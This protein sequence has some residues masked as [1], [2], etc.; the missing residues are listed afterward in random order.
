MKR[1][2]LGV[3]AAVLALSASAAVVHAQNPMNFGIAAG[4]TFPTGDLGEGANTG[5]HGMVTLGAM[6]AMVPF[7]VRIDGMY[8][9][10][11][12]DDAGGF[13]GASSQ[14]L[15]ATANAVFSIPGMMV[16]SPYI[17]GGVGYYSQ[18]IKTDQAD[19]DSDGNIGLNIGIGAKFNLSGF[20]TFAEIRF[21]NIF[22]ADDELDIGN[23]TFIPLTFG[24][25]F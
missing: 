16:T 15:A 4:A 1:T 12:F 10:I 20:G 3:A 13:T 6:P 9:S 22:D 14:I 5:F 2:A 17:I 24:I 7:G 19:G 18:T 25:M 21:H 23:S 8:N 11:G